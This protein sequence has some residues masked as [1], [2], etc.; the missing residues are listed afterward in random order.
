LKIKFPAKTIKAFLIIYWWLEVHSV[1]MLTTI[2]V[3]V[4]STKDAVEKNQS[5]YTSDTRASTSTSSTSTPR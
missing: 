5:I 2:A 4:L 1:Y 3:L